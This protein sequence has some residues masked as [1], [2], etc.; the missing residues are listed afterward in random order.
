M[1]P[2]SQPKRRGES[3]A[4]VRLEFCSVYVSTATDDERGRC[5]DAGIPPS[6]SGR[7]V[8]VHVCFTGDLS[9]VRCVGRCGRIVL[10]LMVSVSHSDPV[11]KGRTCT[12]KRFARGALFRE[13]IDSGWPIRVTR[14]G[15][16]HCVALSGNDSL[17]GSMGTPSGSENEA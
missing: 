17:A 8:W 4:F 3:G 5:S 2:Y 9:R 1:S 16:E 15:R 7:F 11:I 14:R 13:V 12:G 6:T 10:S